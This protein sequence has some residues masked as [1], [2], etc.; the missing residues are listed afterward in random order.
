MKNVTHILLLLALSSSMAHAQVAADNASNYGGSWTNGSNQGSGFLAWALSNNNGGA[1]FAGNFIG[2]STDGAGNI[3]TGGNAFG[4]FANPGAAFSNADRGLASALVT[5]SSFSFD[6]AL[7]F[8]NGN[9]GF[10]LYAGTQGQIFNFNVGNGGSVSS[11]NGAIIA[12]G[13]GSGYNY[14]GNDAVLDFTLTMLSA[15]SFSYDISR[16]SGSGFQGTL[17][18]GSVSGLTQDISGFRFYVSGTDNGDAQNNLYFN[19][20]SVIPEPSSQV[21]LGAGLLALLILARRRAVRSFS[22]PN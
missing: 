10:N 5:G 1:V 18:S 3:N 12:A 8:D 16:A 22:T 20:L 9:K 14:G 19:N 21:L 2:N 11:A 4:L 7:N 6:L 15:T 13:S 17:F